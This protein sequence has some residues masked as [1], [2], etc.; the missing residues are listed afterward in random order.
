MQRPYRIGFYNDFSPYSDSKS[1]TSQTGIFYDI[2]RKAKERHNIR[3]EEI[4]IDEAKFGVDID[5]MVEKGTYDALLIPAFVNKERIHKVNFTRPVMLNKI[6]I[7]YKPETSMFTS[8]FKI[9]FSTVLPPIS[10]LILFGLTF[11]YLLYLIEPKRGKTRAIFSTVASMFGEMGFVSENSSLSWSGMVIAFFIMFI[12]FYFTIFLQAATV[13]K[14]SESV[15]SYELSRDN[16]AGKK[17][18]TTKG[19]SYVHILKQLG[20]IPIERK[21]VKSAVKTYMNSLLTPKRYD[22]F[23]FD[24]ETTYKQAQKHGLAMTVE[25][26]GHNEIAFPVTRN[27]TR[28][29]EML[30]ETI[31]TLQDNNETKGICRKYMNEERSGYCE[32]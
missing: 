20:A 19:S 27:N 10:I 21:S 7:A 13:D 3:S 26:F 24:Y 23:L 29:L 8:F 15:S 18:V 22:G 4:F 31:V 17:I 6:S 2:W 12:S 25:N 30:N 5:E 28:L 9:L 14:F 32:I 1:K 16:I 11:G